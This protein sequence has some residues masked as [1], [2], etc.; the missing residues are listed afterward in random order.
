[1]WRYDQSNVPVTPKGHF[2]EFKENVVTTF[3]VAWP[4]N[5]RLIGLPIY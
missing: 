4:N 3:D 1:M 5:F 2:G